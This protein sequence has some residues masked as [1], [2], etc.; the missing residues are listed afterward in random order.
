MRWN[1]NKIERRHHLQI[2]VVVMIIVVTSI[3]IPTKIDILQYNDFITNGTSRVSTFVKSMDMFVSDNFK[4]YNNSPIKSEF[5]IYDVPSVA[6]ASSLE[7]VNQ[8]HANSSQPGLI[9]GTYPVG[10]AVNPVTKKIYVTDEFSNTVSVISGTSNTVESTITVGNFPYG[11]AINPFDSRVYVT[12][13]GSNT[14]S[15]IDGSTNTKLHNITVQN[16][17]VGIA[18]NP[19]ANWIYVTNI[20]SNTVSIIDG[21]TDK[22]TA[23]ITVGKIPYGVAANP[24]TKK[25]YVTNIGSN[26]VSVI[27]GLKNKV[28]ANITV[29]KNPVGIAVNPTI[30]KAYVTNIESNTVSVIDAITDKVIGTITVNPSLGGSYKIHDPILSMPITAKFPLIASLVAVNDLSNMI[31][32]T[33]TGSDT[34]SIIDGNIDS[35]VV[36]VSFNINPPNSGD[37]QCNGQQIIPNTY[38]LY[39]NGTNL[40]C[41]ANSDRGYKFSSWSNVLYSLNN[42]LS[43]NLSQYGG[44]LTANFKPTL[45]LEQYLAIILGPISIVSITVGWILRNRQRRHLDKY[46][47]IIDTAYESLDQN[48]TQSSKECLLHLQL[49]RKE[50]SQLFKKGKISDAYYN[51]LDKKISE[52]IEKVNK[53]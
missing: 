16:S 32:V 42:P 4:I 45:S 38:F 49:V 24:I 46:M 26:T 18:L 20:N 41:T 15:V 12:N 40:T 17:P 19:S 44:T 3:W 25:V 47:T 48:N 34:L 53:I 9:V 52:Y 39:R 23:N 8:G 50:I 36:K 29:G 30:N 43:F 13:R 31:Y 51:I 5:G 27:D 21:I 10:V 35:I 11:V 22:V 14:V 1:I 6:A 2:A 7:T 33:N 37:I 28:T